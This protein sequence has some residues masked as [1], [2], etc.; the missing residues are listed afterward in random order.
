MC[1][2]TR[3]V[4]A[5]ILTKVDLEAAVIIL[6]SN[7]LNGLDGI[8]DIGEVDECAALLSKSVDELN[9]AVLREVLSQP[10]FGPRLVQVSNVDVSGRATADSKSNRCWERTRMFAP[11]NLQSPIVNH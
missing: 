4:A 8:G 1:D 10:L 3:W 7:S 6:A 5:T 9:F 2:L 11:S